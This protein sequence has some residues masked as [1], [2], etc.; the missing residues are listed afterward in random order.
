MRSRLKRK[1]PAIAVASR[2][3][4]ATGRSISR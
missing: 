2:S 3:W 1:R 4:R